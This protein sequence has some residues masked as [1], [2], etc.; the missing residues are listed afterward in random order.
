MESPG[1]ASEMACLVVSQAVVGDTF[2][3]PQCL[4]G[5]PGSADLFLKSAA[6]SFFQRNKLQEFENQN[7]A[8][9]PPRTCLD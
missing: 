4:C 8:L 5:E 1:E 2:S 7:S 9:P 6:F 3:V